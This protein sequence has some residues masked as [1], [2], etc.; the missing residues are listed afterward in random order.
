MDVDGVVVQHQQLLSEFVGTST[1]DVTDPFWNRF[2]SFPVPLMRLP[3][4]EL[5]A[6][7]TSYCEQLGEP[8]FFFSL[9]CMHDVKCL[10]LFRIETALSWANFGRLMTVTRVD[11]WRSAKQ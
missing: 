6:A 5:E 1:R 4:S 2:L 8:S 10:R 3:P 11:F 7:T 9:T